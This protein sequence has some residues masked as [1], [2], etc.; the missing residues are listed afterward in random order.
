MSN[1]FMQEWFESS[2]SPDK[3]TI[4]EF[5]KYVEEYL[6]VRAEADELDAQLTEKNKKMSA[7][8]S[9]LMEYLAAMGKDKHVTRLGTISK[10]ETLSYK[11]PEGE[12]REE[13]YQLLRD[14]GQYDNVMAFNAKKFSSW[15]K[16][17]LD[18]DSKFSVSGVEPSVTKYIRFVKGK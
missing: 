3:V 10:V 14:R 13:L 2:T 1:D 17:E 15:Y 18:A 12:G 16:A 5:D 9:K 11:A 8:S 4:E 7:M 6:A